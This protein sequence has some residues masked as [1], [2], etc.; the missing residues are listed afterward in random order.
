MATIDPRIYNLQ[1]FVPWRDPRFAKWGSKAFWLLFF[2]MVTPAVLTHQ[3]G[4]ALAAVPGYA[5]FVPRHPDFLGGYNP[6]HLGHWYIVLFVQLFQHPN[7]AG[8]IALWN[9]VAL[10]TTIVSDFIAAFVVYQILYWSAGNIVPDY[11]GAGRV[12]TQAEVASSGVFD[13]FDGVYGGFFPFKLSLMERFAALA[14]GNVIRFL[15]GIVNRIMRLPAE[16]HVILFG[17][18]GSGKTQD[19]ILTTL[20]TWEGSLF[21]YALKSEIIVKSAG[22]RASAEGMSSELHVVML[23]KPD[24]KYDPK[25]VD[26]IGS[27]WEGGLNPLDMVNGY[28]DSAE[29]TIALREETGA[30]KKESDGPSSSFFT[31]TSTEYCNI[32]WTWLRAQRGADASLGLALEL[33]S[34]QRTP[35]DLLMAM[36]QQPHD[37]HG[38][39]LWFDRNGVQMNQD[40]AVVN[41][42]NKLLVNLTPDQM[43]SVVQNATTWLSP[44]HDRYVSRATSKTTFDP[45]KCR[46]PKENV[47]IYLFSPYI[48]KKALASVVSVCSHAYLRMVARGDSPYRNAKGRVLAVFDEFDSVNVPVIDDDINEL[49]STGISL[50]L[51]LQSYRM[52]LRKYGSLERIRMACGG[53]I[54]LKPKDAETYKDLQSATGSDSVRAASP[55]NQYGHDYGHAFQDI[56]RTV[57]EEEEARRIPDDRGMLVLDVPG[58]DG[59]GLHP[60]Y[61]GRGHAIHEP[62]FRRRIQYPLPWEKGS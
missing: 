37:P 41:I 49:R 6:A 36:V 39:S 43:Q 54:Y 48:R 40:P 1:A 58:A 12:A 31:V 53:G 46:D 8:P 35:V 13:K 17:G 16:F 30:G 50:L 22:Y 55:P 44:W 23:G 28:E 42:A 29:I 51:A 5:H 45:G 19:I 52:L 11:H 27:E 15:T 32:M 9:L 38:R 57:I 60:I 56:R 7:V 62:E 34:Q 3:L 26:V 10:G 2:V 25:L 24:P 18:T 47:S 20:N 14:S 61:I 4:T 59:A 33:I 21:A